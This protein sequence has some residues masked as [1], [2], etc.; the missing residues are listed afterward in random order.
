MNTNN[1]LKFE[2]FILSVLKQICI[3]EGKPIFTYYDLGHYNKNETKNDNYYSYVRNLIVH[4]NAKFDAYMPNGFLSFDKP[5]FVEIKY[6]IH[7]M[8]FNDLYSFDKEHISLYIVGGVKSSKLL[9][10]R[11]KG[12]NI[13]VW[14]E[15]KIREWEKEFSVDYYGLFSRDTPDEDLIEFAQKNEANRL[16]LHQT[17]KERKLSLALGAGVS[18]D[19]GALKW[20]SLIE[21]FYDEIKKENKI[22]NIE[23]VQNKI[24][25]TAI[26]N[27][28][29]TEDNLK[30][31]MGS[32]YNGIY[33]SYTHPINRY[34]DS[35]IS[36]LIPLIKKLHNSRRFNI[37]TYNYDDYLEQFLDSYFIPYNILYNE[38]GI[39]DEKL[40]VYHPHGFLPYTATKNTFAEFQKYIVFS[41]GEYHNLYNDPYEWAS[42]LQYFLYRESIYLFVGCSLSDP[43]LRRILSSTKIKG[44]MHFALMLTGGLTK[45]DQFIVHRHFMRMGVEC[46]WTDDINEYKT[47]LDN[48]A[49]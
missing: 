23:A 10:D 35:T 20:T 14:G 39:V 42:I 11:I 38:E 25:G 3:K 26:I 49:L 29:F 4:N 44:K 7:N 33:A 6:N 27:G 13:Y 41:E 47:I 9:S 24:G 31:F 46:I 21:A 12:K 45:K 32:L 18:I 34:I 19:F 17:V 5:V 2:E 16:L 22:D 28:Q 8:S 1:A 37:I 36:H 48:I 15:E 43:N 40:N 30:D